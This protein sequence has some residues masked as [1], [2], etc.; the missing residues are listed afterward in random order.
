MKRSARLLCYGEKGL[1]SG[2]GAKGILRHS[3]V[4]LHQVLVEHTACANIHVTDFTVAHLAV[5]QTHIFPIG[6]KRGVRVALGE[7]G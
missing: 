5:R 3:A 6:A 2:E 7:G 4:D 1:N